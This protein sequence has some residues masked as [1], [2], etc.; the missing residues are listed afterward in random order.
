VRLATTTL[1]RAYRGSHCPTAW[2]GVWRHWRVGPRAR[3]LHAV[4]HLL[5]IR[6]LIWFISKGVLAAH[7]V[8]H[9]HGHVIGHTARHII[10]H[11]ARHVI[12]HTARHVIGHTARHIVGHVRSAPHRT[13][14]HHRHAIGPRATAP[15][16]HLVVVHLAVG[17]HHPL[18]VAHVAARLHHVVGHHAVV[19]RHVHVV[20]RAHH[21]MLG[22]VIMHHVT[23]WWAPGSSHG[24]A[25]HGTIGSLHSWPHHPS[26]RAAVGSHVVTHHVGSTLHHVAV[27]STVILVT[28]RAHHV[29]AGPLHAWPHVVRRRHV[30]RSHHGSPVR[31]HV[32]HHVVSHHALSHVPHVLLVALHVLIRH[33][34]LG[35]L[36]TYNAQ[37]KVLLLDSVNKICNYIRISSYSLYNMSNLSF[38]ISV[39]LN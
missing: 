18:L 37:G 10:G 16:H 29:S 9:S 25:H 33:A 21:T 13:G 26:L 7:A 20:H 24:T 6:F 2:N 8:V 5:R 38:A 36:R 28:H 11:T 34:V 19:G 31:P 1:Y 35:T 39:I 14:G 17:R 30:V 3:L 15:S 22:H 12:G 32:V 4:R 27:V 23:L